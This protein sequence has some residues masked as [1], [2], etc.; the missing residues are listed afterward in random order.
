MY[1]Y[2][3]ENPIFVHTGIYN[4]HLFIIGLGGLF[5][6][7]LL[8]YYTRS[9]FLNALTHRGSQDQEWLYTEYTQ[10]TKL[11]IA[12]NFLIFIVFS[13][14]YF[15]QVK[16]TLL[17][18]GV[19]GDYMLSI[20]AQQKVWADSLFSFSGSF[21]QGLG[22]NIWFP[23]NTLNDPGYKIGSIMGAFNPALAHTVWAL[24]LFVSA[25]LLARVA[26]LNWA[27]TMLAA[28]IAPCLILYPSPFQFSKVPALIPHMSTSI[29]LTALLV[30]LTIIRSGTLRNSALRSILITLIV[31]YFS[32]HNPTFMLLAF[33]LLALCGIVKLFILSDR[34]DRLIE[35]CVFALPIALIMVTGTFEFVA[36]LFLNTSVHVFPEDFIIPEKKISSISSI[37]YNPLSAFFCLLAFTGILASLIA[38]KIPEELKTLAISSALLCCF[39]FVL[40]FIYI[41]N[42]QIWNGPSV[43][44]FEFMLWPVYAVFTTYFC[45]RVLAFM[46]LE[47]LSIIKNRQKIL[48]V[49][50]PYTIP[51]LP[52]I[53]FFF[54]ALD[55][56]S[57]RFWK[58]PPPS[59]PIMDSLMNLSHDPDTPFKGR[60]ATFTGLNINTPVSWMDIQA[61]DYE[62]LWSIDNDFR[63]AGLWINGI[64][65][66]AEYSPLITPAFHF[67]SRELLGVEGDK[68]VRNMMTLRHVSPVHLRMM[69]INRLV[70]D[71]KLEGHK[72]LAQEKAGKHTI[73]LY[74]L[75]HSNTGNWSPTEVI[76]YKNLK[77]AVQKIKLESLVEDNWP[78]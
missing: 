16:E 7:L 9:V 24:L 6:A 33:P 17:F 14:Y 61:L 13:L 11:F 50:L 65:T 32:F 41:R 74:E 36:G 52:V 71:A 55:H 54:L 38:S 21:L 63:K 12:F 19:D 35:C 29:F 73:F 44:Y 37:F 40:G 27:S 77:E 56:P 31:L 53:L 48:T 23:L 58:F 42:P 22:G 45:I 69:G 67:F 5:L 59:S 75:T 20:E 34:K 39:I 78:K 43:N 49:Y 15:N 57:E 66:L 2:G 46:R 25:L 47:Q 64:P 68:Q 26:K 60:V 3:E 76:V 18:L 70:T 72:L 10:N 1:G 4:G 28:W 30:A 8:N 51:L 62:V